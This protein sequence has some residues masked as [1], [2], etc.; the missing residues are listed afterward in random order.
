MVL[1]EVQFD[2]RL[3]L[4][5]ILGTCLVFTMISFAKHNSVEEMPQKRI[6]LNILGALFLVL[7]VLCGISSIVDL[8]KLT[9]P[10]EKLNPYSY[11]SLEWEYPTLE[12]KSVIVGIV[13]FYMFLSLAAYLFCFRKSISSWWKKISKVIYIT[14]LFI[15]FLFTFFCFDVYEW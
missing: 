13:S 5:I 9:H 14:L 4:I 3:Y 8:T 11:E 6:G 10:T 2:F 12:Q 1:L 7:A 15:L